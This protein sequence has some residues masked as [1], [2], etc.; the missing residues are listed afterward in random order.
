MRGERGLCATVDSDMRISLRPSSSKDSHWEFEIRCKILEYFWGMMLILLFVF[1]PIRDTIRYADM[2]P[3][4]NINSMQE[5]IKTITKKKDLGSHFI[6]RKM[7]TWMVEQLEHT[8]SYG[9]LCLE[10]KWYDIILNKQR[11]C[12]LQWKRGHG[13]TLDCSRR[14]SIPHT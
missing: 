13:W 14:R 10:S 11:M 12:L 2:H 3:H 6:S 7:N 8:S 9:I 5:S 4:E 1:W